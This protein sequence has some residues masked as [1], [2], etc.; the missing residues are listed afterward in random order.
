M[1][2]H[3]FLY[4]WSCKVSGE[5][6]EREIQMENNEVGFGV[7]VMKEVCIMM[8]RVFYVIIINIAFLRRKAWPILNRKN[9]N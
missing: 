1:I 9:C 6:G 2:L 4:C 3:R 8:L 5:R 7:R